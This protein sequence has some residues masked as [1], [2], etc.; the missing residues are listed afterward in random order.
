M[1]AVVG[2]PRASLDPGSVALALARCFDPDGPEVL[3]I[4][5]DATGTALA[6]RLGDALRVDLSP[7]VRG[8]PSLM[9]T[10][11]PPAAGTITAHCHRLEGP[12]MPPTLLLLSPTSQRGAAQAA[13]WLNTHAGDVA[14]LDGRFRVVV[15]SS[16]KR[17]GGDPPLALL[18]RCDTLVLLAPVGSEADRAELSD[19]FPDIPPAEEDRQRRLLL[20]EAAGRLRPD[21]LSRLTPLEVLGRLSAVADARLLA[22]NSSLRRKLGQLVATLDDDPDSEAATPAEQ[23]P[24]ATRRRPEP[25]KPPPLGGDRPA[26]AP[27]DSVGPARAAPVQ[28]PRRSKLKRATDDDTGTGGRPPPVT[29]PRRS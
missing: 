8:L 18:R 25:V 20:A 24:R 13:S 19:P 27:D 4:D 16:F 1:L 9:A 15:S 22:P 29:P 7:A 12:K 10:A 21:E 6:N 11:E 2:S 23:A 3:F 26:P 17:L 28:P 14:A 5:A